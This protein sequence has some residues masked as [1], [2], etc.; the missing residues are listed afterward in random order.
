MAAFSTNTTNPTERGRALIMMRDLTPGCPATL[1][2]KPGEGGF[3]QSPGQA[4]LTFQELRTFPVLP[5]TFSATG[6]HF[7]FPPDQRIGG[8]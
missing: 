1:T 5:L 2:L 4:V 3:F 7:A 8:L 6:L